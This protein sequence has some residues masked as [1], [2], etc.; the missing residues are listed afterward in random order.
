MM[1]AF[2]VGVCVALHY[3]YCLGVIFELNLFFFLA[4]I[5][6]WVLLYLEKMILSLLWTGG[7]W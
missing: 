7:D 6:N 5:I 4:I 1:I 2:A 3:C